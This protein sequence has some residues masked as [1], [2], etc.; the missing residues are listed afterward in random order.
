[1]NNCYLHSHVHYQRS[2]TLETHTPVCTM[3][4]SM[5]YNMVALHTGVAD[6]QGNRILYTSV[7]VIATQMCDL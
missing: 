4:G 6:K 1:M 5:P 7:L 2:I 3:G